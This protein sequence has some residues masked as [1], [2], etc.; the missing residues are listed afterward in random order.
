MYK[1]GGNMAIHLLDTALI[2]KIA[3][4]EVIERPASVVK[5]LVEN[6]IDAGA[7]SVTIEIRDG[8]I[9]YIRVTDNGCGIAPQEVKTAF[10]RH[11]TSKLL[12]FDDL[13]SILTLGFR[14]EALSSIAAVSQTE[15]ITR[16]KDEQTGVKIEI[17][18]GK[19]LSEERVAANIGTSF[20]VK[21]LFYNTPARRKFLKKPAAE[22][23]HISDMVNKIALGQPHISFKL[24]NNGSTIIH[25]SGSNDIKTAIFHIYG[26]DAAKK[27]LDVEISKN[28]F[29]LKGMTG[30]PEL[31]RGN[32]S[33]ENFFVNGRFIKSSI[34]QRAVEDAYKGRLTVGKFPVFVINLTAGANTVDVNVHP[35]KLEV[36]FADEDFIYEFIKEGIL[37]ALNNEDLIPEAQIKKNDFEYIEYTEGEQ[38]YEAEHQKELEE[39]LLEDDMDSFVPPE[40]MFVREDYDA[41]DI[42]D[43]KKTEKAENT[44]DMDITEPVKAMPDKK[45]KPENHEKKHT[46]KRSFFKNYKIIGQVFNTY[47]IVEQGSSVFMIDQH[48]AHERVLYEKLINELKSEKTVSQRLIQSVAVNL[49][50][51]EINTVEE[52]L[53]L[54]ESFGFELDRFGENT[55]AVRAV[56][57]I[58]EGP[59]K[60]DFFIDMVDMLADDKLIGSIYETKLDL[61]ASMSCKA[62]VKGNNSLSFA[63]AKELIEKMLKLENPFSCPHGR[64]TVIEIS[65]YDIEKNFKRIQ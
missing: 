37:N 18:G 14:G 32:R 63:Q 64:P 39:L 51:N 25:T 22:S 34:V 20:V 57:F 16:V 29:T 61:I 48:A 9:N 8:G 43:I 21:N 53:S 35:A 40:P 1:E 26:K 54:L 10:L 44:A 49:S 2:N 24:I 5:E 19:V 45:P 50:L 62:A 42:K 65:K 58:F 30:K 33:Y 59:I 7:T 15:L 56:P 47:W 36:R 4:G 28:N 41:E 17:H 38:K 11:A 46:E 31:S 55:Y 52:N 23:G 6:S 3:A 13:M 27:M 12:S 60:P